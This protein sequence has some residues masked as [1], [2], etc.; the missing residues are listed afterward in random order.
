VLDFPE[1]TSSRLI[2]AKGL[3]RGECLL[4]RFPAI[5]AENNARHVIQSVIIDAKRNLHETYLFR[6]VVTRHLVF[7]HCVRR[8][9]VFNP[10][11]ARHN[12]TPLPLLAGL[13]AAVH[14]CS[15]MQTVLLFC[16]HNIVLFQ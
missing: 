10:L 8:S 4:P 16:G 6:R 1:F 7:D 14:N 11:N 5:G 13:F 3:E 15:N 2:P 9:I 12:V